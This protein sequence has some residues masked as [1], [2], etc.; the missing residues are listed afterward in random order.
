[1]QGQ[2]ETGDSGGDGAGQQEEREQIEEETGDWALI[3]NRLGRQLL[4]LVAVVVGGLLCVKFLAIAFIYVEEKI[5]TKFAR[6]RASQMLRFGP[7]TLK[8]Q[9]SN[10]VVAV[11]FPKAQSRA[12]E[13]R[14]AIRLQAV[15]R[16]KM[17]RREME[18]RRVLSFNQNQHIVNSAAKLQAVVR[19]RRARAEVGKPGSKKSRMFAMR[20]QISKLNARKNAEFANVTAHVATRAPAMLET[21]EGVAH[22]APAIRMGGPPARIM[23]RPRAE[24]P[25][26]PPPPPPGGD[27]VSE[28]SMR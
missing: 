27:Y 1:M 16:S 25:P 18:R 19:G 8:G 4:D 12:L 13:E 6:L 15:W 28:I 3:A 10:P 11:F 17:S 24:P 23:P 26:P 7:S 22:F 14:M 5:V 20:M 9:S 2:E 21:N